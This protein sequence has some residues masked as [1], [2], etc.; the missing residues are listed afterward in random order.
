MLA[1]ISYAAVERSQ[2]HARAAYFPCRDHKFCRRWPARTPPEIVVRS[3]CA[4]L[5]WTTE[6]HRCIGARA[7]HTIPAPPIV[8]QAYQTDGTRFRTPPSTRYMHSQ[9]SGATASRTSLPRNAFHRV[10]LCRSPT[11]RCYTCTITE[12]ENVTDTRP[13]RPSTLRVRLH[14]ERRREGLRLLTL[15]MPEP[16]M[17][18]R[19]R[20]AGLV[21]ASTPL[22]S[23]FRD[24]AELA[25]RQRSYHYR[26]AHQCG[27]DPPW[28]QRLAGAGAAHRV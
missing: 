27:C 1:D 3:V 5:A 18:P 11:K 25:D 17:T 20:G 23:T 26:R 24:G 16:A 2:H 19:S 21:K 9:V 12:V 8:T 4:W 13:V 7:A 15:E 28:Y 6:V 10:R 14:R 22:N